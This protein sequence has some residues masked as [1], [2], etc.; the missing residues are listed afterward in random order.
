MAKL[1]K[2]HIEFFKN[3]EFC[4]KYLQNLDNRLIYSN[5]KIEEEKDNKNRSTMDQLYDHAGVLSLQDN[6]D[7]FRMLL[8]KLNDKSDRPL[9]QEFII[10]VANTINKHAL[11]I[12]DGYRE[13]GKGHK[14][15]DQFPIADPE[16]IEN[17]MEKLLDNYYGKWKDLDIYERE[18]LFNI[19]FLRI[20]PFEDGNGRTSRLILNFNMLWQMH[21]PVI[22]PEVMRNEYFDARNYNDVDFIKNMFERLSEE[23]LKVMGIFYNYLEESNQ[24][25]FKM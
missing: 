2:K 3:S 18:A 22:I 4:E 25:S 9:T 8:N 12:S 20:H 24:K 10:E 19:E 23:E 13:I 15:K 14:L 17:D 5:N 7:A 16:D 1:E 6:S 21:A 11:Y